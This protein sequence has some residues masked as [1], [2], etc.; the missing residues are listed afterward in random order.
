M[1]D[2]YDDLFAP[3]YDAS[4]HV[5]A[6]RYRFPAPPGVPE[7]PNGWMRTSNAVSA[8]SDQKALMDWLTW[9]MMMGLRADDGLIFDEWMATSLAGLDEKAAAN[10]FAELARARAG[11]SDAARRGNARHSMMETWFTNAVRSGT[12]S[13]LLQLDQVLE[14][15]DK[16]EYDPIPGTFETKLWN[17]AGGGI[18]GTRDLR[19]VCRRTGQEG[20][21][22]WKTQARF[23]TFQEIA[24]QLYTYDSATWR[25]VPPFDDRGSWAPAES[26][27]LVG[28]P[29][30][31]LAGKRVALVVHMPLAAEVAVKQ[32]DLEYGRQVLEVAVRNV[33]LRSVGRSRSEKRMPAEDLTPPL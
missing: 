7:S 2:D 22:D 25:W 4:Y 15:L 32:V 31:R 6:G 30:T 33:E 5:R 24:G 19:V 17:P 23:W 12:R 1:T 3:T 10:A 16:L 13:M 26:N 20:V 14:L 18:M 8:F 11:A 27:D 28:R 9:K 21:A 29:G